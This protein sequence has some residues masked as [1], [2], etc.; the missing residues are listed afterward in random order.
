MIAVIPEVFQVLFE[1]AGLD[2]HT[3]DH[4]RSEAVIEQYWYADVLVY[5]GSVLLQLWHRSMGDG[6]RQQQDGEKQ[7][8]DMV[9]H[10]GKTS[11]S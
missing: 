5:H 10:L 9:F 1:N 7:Q 2:G 8:G 11:G 4:G 3:V 6:L